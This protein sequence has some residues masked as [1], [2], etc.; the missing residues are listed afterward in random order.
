MCLVSKPTIWLGRLN[1]HKERWM[2]VEERRREWTSVWMSSVPWLH[3][4]RG[5]SS[6]V[7][8][9]DIRVRSRCRLWASRTALLG[10]GIEGT[11]DDS[12][13]AQRQHS[14][15][16]VGCS[17]V[18]GS[19]QQRSGHGSLSWPCGSLAGVPTGDRLPEEKIL[20]AGELAKRESER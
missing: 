3:S 8:L 1:T 13:K 2:E 7:R 6:S 9:R 17:G 19:L 10:A 15:S 16:C 5:L 12:T 11:A 20:L 4:V 14:F 18:Q